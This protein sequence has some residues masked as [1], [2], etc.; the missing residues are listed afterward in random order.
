MGRPER[1]LDP[2]AGPIPRFAGALRELRRES[3][4]A[5]YRTLA[6]RT[7]FSASTLSEAAAGERLPSLAV[8]LAYVA[9]CGGDT[10]EWEERWRQAAD[11][12]AVQPVHDDGTAVPPYL[13]LSRFEPDDRSRFHGRE[14]LVAELEALTRA[15]RLTVVVGASGSG[16]SSL[17]RAGLIPALRSGSP[18][19]ERPAAVRILT[20][21]EQ[22]A[23]SHTAV[24]TASERPGD[25]WILVD[26]FEQV[27][28]LCQN[29]V[30]RV[31]FRD[32]L[33]RATAA[34]SRLRVILSMRAD[35]S[36]RCGE[37]RELMET[38][39][40]A[41]LLV[42][43]MSRD[44][45]REAIIRPAAAQGLVLERALTAQVIED[46]GD[47]PGSLPLMSHALLETWR[48]RRGKMLTLAGY[49]A[50]GGLHG[51]IAQT[52]EE[53]YEQLTPS[54]AHL[55]RLIL[56]RLVTPGEGAQD[57]RRPAPF[58]ELGSL[59]D[60][61]A[62]P[63]LDRLAA[64]RLITL[65]DDTVDLAHEALITSWPRLHGWIDGS[66]ERLRLH[67]R[68]TESAVAWEEL[69]RDPEELYGG[70]RL[71][72]AEEAFGDT[73]ELTGLEQAFLTASLNARDAE[74][75][76]AVRAVRRTRLLALA[77]G[78]LLLVTVVTMF[79]ASQQQQTARSRQLAAQSAALLDTQPDLAALLAVMA[80]RTDPTSEAVT[81]LYDIAAVPLRQ[82]LTDE[83]GGDTRAA[84]FSPD[85]RVLATGGEDGKVRLW[86]TGTG[87]IHHRF[88]HPDAVESLVFARDGKTLASEDARGTLRLWDTAGGKKL[89]TLA[90]CACRLMAFSENG[91]TLAASSETGIRLWDTQT[92]REQ[93]AIGEAGDP[94]L[95]AAVNPKGNII[96][97]RHE[98]RI[99]LWESDT[100]E[101]LSSSD[102]SRESPAFTAGMAFAPDGRTLAVVD[103][104]RAWLWD[105]MTGKKM[106][107]PESVSW[108]TVT[109]L[110]FSPGGRALATGH[111]SGLVHIWDV[112]HLSRTG[113]LTF[114]DARGVTSVAFGA[115]GHT[116]LAGH[117]TS[118]AQ[119][120]DVSSSTPL[121]TL[122]GPEHTNTVVFSPDRRTIASGHTGAVRLWDA[123][124]TRHIPPRSNTDVSRLDFTAH[125]SLLAVLERNTSVQHDAL[126]QG[127]DGRTGT[128]VQLMDLRGKS[129]VSSE[130]TEKEFRTVAV[131]G[132]RDTLAAIGRR[133]SL[134]SE[135]EVILWDAENGERRDS[136]MLGTG[137]GVRSAALGPQGRFLATGNRDGTIRLWN[138][139]TGEEETGFT[140]SH[141][142]VSFLA[143]SPDGRTLAGASS[144]T[145]GG[146]VRLWD[147][148]TGREKFSLPGA[149]GS[150]SS[151]A[152]SPDG[153]VLAAGTDGQDGR[154]WL[155]NA[156][157]GEQHSV[158]TGH[159][160]GITS[161]AFSP[162]G[163]LLASAGH[164]SARVWDTH[165][166]SLREVVSGSARTG[167]MG[168]VAFSPDGG[169]LAISDGAHI[170]LRDFPSGPQ[171]ALE[172]ICRVSWEVAEQQ[173]AAYLG[174]SSPEEICGRRGD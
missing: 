126:V 12:D 169:T 105:T 53:L 50:A 10:G 100:G 166:S 146:N 66:R 76:H 59:H 51:A 168:A 6:A 153:R 116:L 15:H 52:A 144:G 67:R 170:K 159:R 58:A 79:E 22:P 161:V 8:A 128:S 39:R 122:T 68:L 14:R 33:L 28:T 31:R 35:F 62:A 18:D 139:E 73:D 7:E 26:Q 131:S 11:E 110:A 48:R 5:G 74:Q 98:R 63:L 104:D 155:W 121:A 19:A 138:L 17:L 137:R 9:A 77:L 102:G 36:G 109:S 55:T 93:T 160:A 135:S 95:A 158:L 151:L 96:A 148:R 82:H 1:P 56:L 154:I 24:F 43:P 88:P 145:G 64:A 46:A 69:H 118:Q 72:A 86:D 174:G 130:Y 44:E 37:N 165:T 108:E 124:R 47:E 49:Q 149:H 30:E 114:G 129:I 120:W 142:P 163:R 134:S 27:F 119:L 103:S 41:T 167:S 150:V 75:R 94:V 78:F 99:R 61:E 60:G 101:E 140:R 127:E 20:P 32:L 4:G 147:I 3:G 171:D 84:V 23:R 89:H 172:R 21:G 156:A 107:L 70:S 80:Y 136:M 123:D 125:G 57:S 13:G 29:S 87:G 157:K 38:L 71:S 133:S 25:T 91:S 42:A 97:T 65:G 81:S 54:Q 162:D 141:E 173:R 143:F 115:D 164:E 106:L 40:R 112:E 34:E 117:G 2:E 152:F 111:T 92:G 16:K 113:T 45:L 85:G 90:R 132:D 83:A